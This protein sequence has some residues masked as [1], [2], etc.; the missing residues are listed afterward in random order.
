[1]ALAESGTGREWHW[2][3]VAL[4][5]SGTDRE[6]HWQ[7][8]A[9]P[10]STPCVAVALGEESRPRRWQHTMRSNMPDSEASPSAPP[11][12]WQRRG[13]ADVLQPESPS[14]S[15]SAGG[16]HSPLAPDSEASPSAP[17]L[18]WQHT[19]TDS[20]LPVGPRA[21][22]E[23]RVRA[24]VYEGGREKVS[25][26]VKLNSTSGLRGPGSERL[27]LESGSEKETLMN[28]PTRP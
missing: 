27:R 8:V 25:P 12:R 11:R 17:P 16:L 10:R 13:G 23:R 20:T 1:V 3:R 26:Q 28:P 15:V 19:A 18:R 5:E 6:W 24:Q 4:A 21:G 2:Q 9:V 22:R 7:R 14:P